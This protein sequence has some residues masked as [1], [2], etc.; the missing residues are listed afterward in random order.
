MLHAGE[1]LLAPQIPLRPGRDGQ[2]TTVG[3]AVQ[4]QVQAIQA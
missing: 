1:D 4:Q 3:T 2:D